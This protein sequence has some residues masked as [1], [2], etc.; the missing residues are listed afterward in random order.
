[1]A[2][3]EWSEYDEGW[4]VGDPEESNVAVVCCVHGNEPPGKRAVERMSDEYGRSEGGTFVLANPRLRAWTAVR[5]RGP[6]PGVPRRPEL[7][8]VRAPPGG[9][10]GRGV[11]RPPRT[12]PPLDGVA[13]DAVRPVPAPERPGP[14]RREEHGRRPRRRHRSGRRRNGRRADWRRRRGGTEPPSGGGPRRPTRSRSAS[15]RATAWSTPHPA[16][17]TR[18]STVSTT[19]VRNAATGSRSG[20][21]TPSGS[22]KG[23]CSPEANAGRC[24][25]RAVLPPCWFRRPVRREVGVQSDARG[26]ALGGVRRARMRGRGG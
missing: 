23:R 5:R 24:G 9:P 7:R 4:T 10:T 16:R 12:R 26:T 20:H 15:S 6:Q 25:G 18:S 19:R 21:G 8:G 14:R 22:R 13:P 11:R 3:D 1:M 2:L 17:W